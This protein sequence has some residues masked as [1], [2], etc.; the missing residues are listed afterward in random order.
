[1]TE[2]EV[3]AILGNEYTTDQ[4]YWEP[5][6][7]SESKR[8]GGVRLVIWGRKRASIMIWFNRNGLVVEK[9]FYAPRGSI[10]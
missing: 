4:E 3:R 8:Q 1:M 6:S 2:A 7:L 10:E 5:E 9:Q